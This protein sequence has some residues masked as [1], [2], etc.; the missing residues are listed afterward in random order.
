M[1]QNTGQGCAVIVGVGVRNGLGGALCIRAASQMPVYA[2][3]RNTEK[4]KDLELELHREGLNIMG[5]T[6]DATNVNQA[7]ALFHLIAVNNHVPELVIYNASEI[8]LPKSFLD[9][10]PD[11][12]ENMWRVYYLGGVMVAQ[13]AIKRMLPQQKGTLIFTGATASLR[14]T[15]NFGAFAAAKSAL[16]IHAQALAKEFGPKGIHVAH[17]ILDG[18]ING[19]RI[20]HAAFG[21]G[22]A[23]LSAKGEDG[24]LD[25]TA[26]A[27]AYWQLHLQHRSAW[28]HELDLRPFREK[29]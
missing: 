27:E 22:K 24:S 29:F 1:Q 25:P 28:T 16:R 8:N 20:H 12:I 19:R 23:L 4:V 11:Y 3:G 10:T 15:A 2:A 17:T 5:A 6:C 18:V 13:E 21:L 9:M 14:G 7:A 26:L